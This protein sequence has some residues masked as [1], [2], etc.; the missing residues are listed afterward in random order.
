MSG[1]SRDGRGAVLYS[2]AVHR[3]GIFVQW[4][5]TRSQE[6]TEDG[7]PWIS[8]HRRRPSCIALHW[9]G[10]AS[11]FAPSCGAG[12][13]MQLSKDRRCHCHHNVRC[14][15]GQAA[16]ATAPPSPPTACL[17]NPDPFESSNITRS[18]SIYIGIDN[19]Y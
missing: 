19:I 8:L 13:C 9:L 17:K 11:L 3:C 1:Q 15:K 5:R 16:R 12:A 18:Y 4:R 7:R 6:R 14:L 2:V 10:L